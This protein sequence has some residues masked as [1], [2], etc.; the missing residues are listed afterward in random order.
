MRDTTGIALGFP[1]GTI[2]VVASR[3][4]LF[5]DRFRFLISPV[6]NVSSRVWGYTFL[7]DASVATWMQPSQ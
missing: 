7:R 4:A 3:L 6:G 5:L 2:A 1:L